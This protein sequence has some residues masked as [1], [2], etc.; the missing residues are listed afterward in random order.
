[1]QQA[2]TAPQ[3]ACSEA[4]RPLS[5]DSR[6]QPQQQKRPPAASEG[7]GGLSMLDHTIAGSGVRRVLA[8]ETGAASQGAAAADEWGNEELGEDLLPL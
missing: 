6:Q 2:A 4:G 8:R 3:P 1:M 7:T 5:S